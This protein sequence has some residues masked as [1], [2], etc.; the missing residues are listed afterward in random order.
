MSALSA[1]CSLRLAQDNGSER[2]SVHSMYS[3]DG[4]IQITRVFSRLMIPSQGINNVMD[5][6][7]CIMQSLSCTFI[8]SKC[9][10]KYFKHI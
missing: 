8:C 7:L 5:T 3:L 1:A 4:H 9:L 10:V 2:K 6:V